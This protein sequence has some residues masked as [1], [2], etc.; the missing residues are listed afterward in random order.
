MGFMNIDLENFMGN[1]SSCFIF[2]LDQTLLTT[3]LLGN[4][5]EFLRS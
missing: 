3:T 2:A 5:D 4:V 1:M